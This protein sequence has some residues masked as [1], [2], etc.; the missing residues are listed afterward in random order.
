MEIYKTKK[1]I[2]QLH[3]F[4]HYKKNPQNFVHYVENQGVWRKKK[5]PIK[6]KADQLD[7]LKKIC[8]L[9]ENVI[10]HE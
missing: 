2:H 3:S 5:T 9:S 1:R 8:I 7:S 10:F 6:L 4:R